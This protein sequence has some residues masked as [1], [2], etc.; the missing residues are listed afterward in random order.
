LWPECRQQPLGEIPPEKLPALSSPDV[1][2]TEVAQSPLEDALP[3]AALDPDAAAAPAEAVVL[4]ACVESLA[5]SP[6][7]CTGVCGS[8]DD[9]AGVVVVAGDAPVDVSVDPNA[10]EVGRV[11]GSDVPVTLVAPGLVCV[12]LADVPATLVEDVLGVAAGFD[13]A[14]SCE[15]DGA[16]T[17]ELVW[18]C[19]APEAT[20][21]RMVAKMNGRIALSVP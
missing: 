5:R 9:E 13:E 4:A 6:G 15:G 10:D 16:S 8:I 17:E 2:G 1:E 21:H 19:V 11:R 18:A 7:N 3:A 12:A 14:F 20:S